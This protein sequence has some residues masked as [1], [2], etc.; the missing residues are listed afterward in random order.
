MSVATNT[1]VVNVQNRD[2]AFDD[3]GAIRFFVVV[4]TP[5][6][7]SDA[8]AVYG[9]TPGSAGVEATVVRGTAQ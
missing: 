2:V 3:A 9:V 1:Y 6:D 8:Y 4:A 5:D 7:D